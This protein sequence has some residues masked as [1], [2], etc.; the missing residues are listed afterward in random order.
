MGANTAIQWCDHTFNPWI[1]CAKVSTGCKFCY[2]E[3]QMD[4]RWNRVQWG[5]G[6]PRIRTT[7]AN[8]RKPLTWNA[9]ALAEGKR[10]RVFCASLADVFDAEAPQGWR[11]DLF[12]L[13]EAT[14][15]L[16]WLLLTKRP[17]SVMHMVPGSWQEHF[18]RNVWLGTSIEN[19]AAANERIPI[20]ATIPASVRFLSIEPLVDEVDLLLGQLWGYSHPMTYVHWIIVGGE[21]GHGAGAMKP[22]WVERL[23]AQARTMHNIPFFFKQTGEVLARE[24]GLKDRKG[25]KLDEV[26]AHL[27]FVRREHPR[28]GWNASS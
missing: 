28:V 12:A 4:H 16:D 3:H 23:E 2:A 9:Q 11:R 1:G 20:L 8:W 22:W 5:P 10:Y 17:G 25:G 15:H 24:L 18:P 14:S 21:S 26:R 13:I 19:Q 27:P 7:V 6:K